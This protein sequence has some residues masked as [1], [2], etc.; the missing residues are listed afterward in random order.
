MK[1]V[2]STSKEVLHMSG[3]TKI[4][5]S[6]GTMIVELQQEVSFLRNRALVLSEMLAQA[7]AEVSRLSAALADMEARATE[8]LLPASGA[9]GSE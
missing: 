6:E 5:I 7:D 9:E 8:A 3:N 4:Q 1:F 2:L